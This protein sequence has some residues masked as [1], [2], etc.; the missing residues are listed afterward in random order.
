VPEIHPLPD[1]FEVA[2]L[3]RLLAKREEKKEKDPSPAAKKRRPNTLSEAK[4]EAEQTS[5]RG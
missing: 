1:G 2:L 5:R 3:V 4:C